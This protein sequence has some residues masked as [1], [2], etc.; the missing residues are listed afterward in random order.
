MK[1]IGTNTNFILLDVLHEKEINSLNLILSNISYFPRVLNPSEYKKYKLTLTGIEKLNVVKKELSEFIRHYIDVELTENGTLVF[2]SDN[3]KIGEYQVG[4]FSEEIC[5]LE[6][7]DW[8]ENYRHLLKEYYKQ[9][10][11]FTKESLLHTWFFERLDKFINE[12][13][14]KAE[15]KC[16][17]FKNDKAKV[18][19]QNEKVSLVDRLENIKEQYL[20]E[21]RKVE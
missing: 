4:N 13:R 18:D 3:H 11:F 5:D 6:K 19:A 12:E 10:D 8:I 17:F 16:E 7:E 9:S 1:I 15:K 20:A 2:W 14:K 21:Y